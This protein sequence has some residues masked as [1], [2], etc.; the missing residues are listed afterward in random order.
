MKIKE[1]KLRNFRNYN[2]LSL[3]P[4]DNFNIIYGENGQGKTNIIEAIF[5]CAS[6]RSHRTSRDTELIRLES[7]SYGVLLNYE[8]DLRDF[9]LEINY[10]KGEKKKIKLNEIPLKKLGDMIGKFNAVIF[11]PDRKSVV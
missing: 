3:E 1:L 7:S 9:S 2:V 4:G 6:G 10:Q 5:L 11:S 8:R